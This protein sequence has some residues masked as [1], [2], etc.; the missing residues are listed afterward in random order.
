VRE[1]ERERERE[2]DRERGIDKKSA[3]ARE[4]TRVPTPKSAK[5]GDEIK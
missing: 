1:R 5:R 3:R 2:P 4:S